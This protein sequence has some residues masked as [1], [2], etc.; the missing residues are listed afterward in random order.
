MVY[1]HV[2]GAPSEELAPFPRKLETAHLQAE[3]SPKC[4]SV[5]SSLSC[6][7]FQLW[8]LWVCGGREPAFWSFPLFLRCLLL[9]L[10]EL[11]F[12]PSTC[13]LCMRNEKWPSRFI[14]GT[15]P[16]ILVHVQTRQYKVVQLLKKKKKGNQARG[17]DYKCV[18][19]AGRRAMLRKVLLSH[20]LGVL[21]AKSR[22]LSA[23][24]RACLSFWT[25]CPKPCSLGTVFWPV[26]R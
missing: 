5:S 2:T 16:S 4:F 22:E 20:L 18:H 12:A 7:L 9:S 23:V 14:G 25:S 19:G 3:S 17:I 11:S 26:A 13:K 15:A 10:P 8:C 6:C 24:F 21:Q 1:Y